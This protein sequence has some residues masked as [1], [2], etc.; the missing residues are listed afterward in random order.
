VARTF[1]ILLLLAGLLASCR[2]APRPPPAGQPRPALWVIEKAPGAPAGWLFSTIH[3]LPAEA[4]W[5]TPELGAAIGAAGVLVVE[6]RDLDP[7]RVSATLA[8]LAR[9]EPAPP[10]AQRLHRR[11]ARALAE[12]LERDGL[13]PGTYDDLETWAAALALARSPRSGGPAATGVDRVLME[14]FAGRP[15]AELEGLERQLALFDDL[16]EREQQAMLAAVLAERADS[17]AQARA[18][19]G[20]WLRG[21]LVAIERVARRGLLADPALYEALLERRNAAWLDPIVQLIETGQRPLVAVGGAH[22][23]GPD[24]LPALL[25][26][27]G[28]RVR[29]LH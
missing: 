7:K 15:I 16:G 3:S 2:E 4:R 1:W 12:R 10:L 24:G 29:R 5:E 21:D 6:V 22:M 28:Y 17:A 11:T 25:A 8:R 13:E 19:A 9:D 26:A 14:R 27:R 18:L 20:A 23:A